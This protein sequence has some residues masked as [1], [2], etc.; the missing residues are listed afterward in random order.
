MAEV[1]PDIKYVSIEPRQL[2]E[3]PVG[4]IPDT[5]APHKPG[6]VGKAKFPKQ[7]ILGFSLSTTVIEKLQIRE[8]PLLSVALYVIVETPSA[9][10]PGHAR[11]THF[12]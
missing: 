4:E 11:P 3:A 12:R 2:S 9:V 1:A 7:L 5:T 10:R 8:F 6:S